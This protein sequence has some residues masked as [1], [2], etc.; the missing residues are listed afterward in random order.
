LT[1]ALLLLVCTSCQSNHGK[2]VLSIPDTSGS[3]APQNA[4]EYVNQL[5]NSPEMLPRER[6][7]LDR[8]QELRINFATQQAM[9]AGKVKIRAIAPV[10]QLTSDESID[11]STHYTITLV[12]DDITGTNTF[13]NEYAVRVGPDPAVAVVAPAVTASNLAAVDFLL[14][15]EKIEQLQLDKIFLTADQSFHATYLTNFG[16]QLSNM[17]ASASNTVASLQ[18]SLSNLDFQ[19]GTNSDAL[20]AFLT[21]AKTNSSSQTGSATN[22]GASL[23]IWMEAQKLQASR[24]NTQQSLTAENA[25]F[26]K[27]QSLQRQNGVAQAAV[28]W[29]QTQIDFWQQESNRLFQAAQLQPA[30][31]ENATN[32]A[33]TIT[34][35]P[36]SL[37]QLDHLTIDVIRRKAPEP[38]KTPPS[39]Q[40][41][42]AAM[43]A[44]WRALQ[45]NAEENLKLL[46]DTLGRFDTSL[47]ELRK[48]LNI[49]P[50]GVTQQSQMGLLYYYSSQFPAWLGKIQAVH[51]AL[52]NSTLSALL[53]NVISSPVLTGNAFDDYSRITNS[54]NRGYLLTNI[55][56]TREDIN[57]ALTKL[58]DAVF[59]T[60]LTYA[61][62]SNIVSEIKRQKQNDYVA[63][64]QIRDASTNLIGHLAADLRDIVNRAAIAKVRSAPQNVPPTLIGF[65]SDL[66]RA[67]QELFELKLSLSSTNPAH[68]SI[69]RQINA[70]LAAPAF[71]VSNRLDSWLNLTNAQIRAEILRS[72]NGTDGDD[73]KLMALLRA[74]T[75][76]PGGLVTSNSVQAARVETNAVPA[77]LGGVAILRTTI[78]EQ[79]SNLWVSAVADFHL[80]TNYA[81]L[82]ADLG[83]VQAVRDRLKPNTPAARQ[84]ESMLS[85]LAV[86]NAGGRFITNT[87]LGLDLTVLDH[88][89]QQ[90]GYL[91]QTLTADDVQVQSYPPVRH[92]L[93]LELNPPE[94]RRALDDQTRLTLRLDG[95]DLTNLN[96]TIPTSPNKLAAPESSIT[97]AIA[98][99]TNGN[100]RINVSLEKYQTVSGTVTN[101]IVVR[102]N[103]ETR[104]IA[105]LQDGERSLKIGTDLV[106]PVDGGGG[107]AP[108]DGGAPAVTSAPDIEGMEARIIAGDEAVFRFNVVHGLVA[109]TAFLVPYDGVVNLFGAHFANQFYVAQVTLSNPNRQPILV[110]GNTL[111][112]IV[113]MTAA[114]PT[115]LGDDGYPMRLN[116]WATYQPMDY[117][118]V[119]LMLQRSNSENWKSR[120]AQFLDYATKAAGFATIFTT[121]IDVAKGIAFFSGIVEPATR[122]LLLED[123]K[124]NEDNFQKVG[125]NQ[126]E[127]IQAGASLTKFLFLPKG[128]IYGDYSY[129]HAL[130][131]QMD[132]MAPAAD[133]NFSKRVLR[134]T[135]IFNI[136]R[137]EAYVEGK[138]ILASDPL[139]S[140]APNQ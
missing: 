84:L 121:S 115:Q 60:E 6:A 75:N 108:V 49:D 130:A 97:N 80:Q 18:N 129:D 8:E 39:A 127:E 14:M 96:T 113:R 42:A 2:R 125:L 128:P 21:Q 63:A 23:A 105:T 32:T 93:R 134:P 64:I 91:A 33:A 135:F 118:A 112:L 40:R 35:R 58:G 87:A 56:K 43:E 31:T 29:N 79:Q 81:Q 71:A 17:I 28:A 133:A 65:Y 54:E 114:D 138:R 72:L 92:N 34:V 124:K 46:I 30:H 24:T 90:A 4:A 1:S 16:G 12:A 38:I 85:L 9:K 19:L 59:K 25:Q 106:E 99:L 95:T 51:L 117:N 10:L 20:T 76:V 123:L 137:E 119:L 47:R 132:L 122:D 86:T 100:L 104:L 83:R 74:V 89:S 139:S 37:R 140:V 52:T 41:G 36:Y 102:V 7:L 26:E 120:A 69:K 126:F 61:L 44:E 45:R 77:L 3:A 110:Y 13:L 131:S 70:I 15:Q 55:F 5:V 88:A 68:S 116:W 66:P 78:D 57:I 50:K 109:T 27:L 73:G 48:I 111:R 136:R 107:G 82:F 11:R 101:R 62:S 98:A 22:P 67:R 94:G 53:T 103:D